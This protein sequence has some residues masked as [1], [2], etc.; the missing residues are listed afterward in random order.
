MI[1]LAALASQPALAR[2]ISLAVLMAPVA[3]TRH[4]TSLPFVLSVKARLDERLLAAGWGEWGAYSPRFS[5]RSMRGCRLLPGLCERYLTSLCGANPRGNLAPEI[6]E[7]VMGHL[8]VGTS[9]MNMALW[10]QVSR[11]PWGARGRPPL[12]AVFVVCSSHLCEGPQT[13]V[14]CE[15]ESVGAARS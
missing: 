8:P 14:P 1:G 3:F 5:A 10:S 4:M 2:R 6:I 15:S 13:N 9:V 12:S 7:L 11:R